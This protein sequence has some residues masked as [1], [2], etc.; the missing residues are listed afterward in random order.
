MASLRTFGS[1]NV[2]LFWIVAIELFTADPI[3]EKLADVYGKGDEPEMIKSVIE[4]ME[5]CSATGNK[6]F[7]WFRNLVDKIM[8]SR[9][10]RDNKWNLFPRGLK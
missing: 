3:N 5:L 8:Y 2:D 9:S 1:E 10:T 4:I 7:R 6:H